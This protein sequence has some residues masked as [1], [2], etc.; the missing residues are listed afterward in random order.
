MYLTDKKCD[1]L[2]TWRRHTCAVLTTGWVVSFI[3]TCVVTY[4][5]TYV[6]TYINTSRLR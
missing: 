4:M 3:S 1:I 2:K 6:Y 5:Y